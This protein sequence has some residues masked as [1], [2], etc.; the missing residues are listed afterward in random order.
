[1][2]PCSVCHKDFKRLDKHMKTHSERPDVPCQHDGCTRVFS[3]RDALLKHI[4]RAHWDVHAATCTRC[5]HHS[6]T[7]DL[8]RAHMETCDAKVRLWKAGREKTHFS[9]LFVASVHRMLLQ[10]RL[11]ASCR[12][13]TCAPS[14]SPTCQRRLTPAA[15]AQSQGMFAFGANSVVLQMKGSCALVVGSLRIGGALV[16]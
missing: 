12:T 4:R 11:Y 14:C 3:S 15:S 7:M 13:N 8:H 16:Y 2:P 10:M 1:M 6:R 5:H 9:F